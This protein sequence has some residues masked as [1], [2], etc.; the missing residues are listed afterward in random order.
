[1][2]RPEGLAGVAFG[3]ASD[4]DGR[5]DPVVRTD[6]SAALGISDEWAV[7]R[8]VHGADV[9]VADVPGGLGDA[10]GIVTTTSG[11][12]IAIG[13]ADCLPVVLQGDGGV[14]I[15]HAGWRGAAAGVVAAVSQAMDR[16]GAP[17][18]RAA[19]GPGIGPCCFE[20]GSEVAERFPG[21]VRTTTWGTTSVDLVD[22]VRSQ[23][24]DVDDVWVHGGCTHHEDVFHSF[25]RD[26]SPQRQVAVAWVPSV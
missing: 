15:A 25:R 17:A 18:R 1:M 3:E 14:G 12:P 6:I 13:I 23:L 21:S 20:V 26:G 5:S 9:A 4:G 24:G 2:I 19:I 8:Q 22:A 10:D 16:M 7:V 11:L